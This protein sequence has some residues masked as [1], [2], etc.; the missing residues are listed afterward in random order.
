ME[1]IYHYHQPWEPLSD[2]QA[3]GYNGPGWY[4]W[5]ET[6]SLCYGPYGSRE[7]AAEKMRE[8]ATTL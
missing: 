5:D 8:Y 7:E 4:F 2:A 1:H 3:A 6:E